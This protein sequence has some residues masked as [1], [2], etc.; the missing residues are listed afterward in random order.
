MRYFANR[1]T[2]YQD[3]KIKEA[4]KEIASKKIKV[5]NQTQTL[6]SIR[7][8]IIKESKKGH[9][10][11][12]IDHL[13]LIEAND[14]KQSLYSNTTAIMKGLRRITRDYDCTIFVVSQVKSSEKSKDPPN[15]SDLR[16]SGEI[17]QSATTVIF[18][19]DPNR[20]VNSSRKI[21]PIDAIIKKNRNGEEGIITLEYDR[22]CQRFNEKGA[23]VYDPNAWRNRKDK[24]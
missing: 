19:H 17:E 16:D 22:E 24:K 18:L 15:L 4:C 2:D 10:I 6:A 7:R 13:G 1:E 8:T 14:S 3:E 12:F 21:V 9:V 5:F 20:D 23:E 11:A